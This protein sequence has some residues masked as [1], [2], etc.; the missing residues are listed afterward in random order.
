MSRFGPGI[1]RKKLSRYRSQSLDEP[2]I[3]MISAIV[4]VQTGRASAL[5]ALPD[6]PVDAIGAELGSSFHFPLRSLATLVNEFLAT[7]KPKTW[8]S[9]ELD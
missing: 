6:L 1:H 8:S 5:R 2:M 3:S 7:S 9:V 4:A